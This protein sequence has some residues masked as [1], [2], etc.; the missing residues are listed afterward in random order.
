MADYLRQETGGVV[1]DATLQAFC[2]RSRE[3][4]GWL[5]GL[6]VRFAATVPPRKTSYPAQSL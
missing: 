5:E 6:G 3:M 4:I 2:Q 1:S